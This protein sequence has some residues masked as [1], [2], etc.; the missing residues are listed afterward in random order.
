MHGVTVED[1]ILEMVRNTI[2]PT[3]LSSKTLSRWYIECEV[4]ESGV[5]LHLAFSLPLGNTYS[6]VERLDMLGATTFGGARFEVFGD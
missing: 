4:S 1:P 5:S 3:I 2:D 6:V